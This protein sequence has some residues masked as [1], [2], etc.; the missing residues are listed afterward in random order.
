TQQL[1]PDLATSWKVENAGRTIVFQLREGIS[2][3]DGT[4][5]TAEDV[6]Y[7]MQVLMDPN[8]HSPTGDT[9]RS[10][11]GAVKTVVRGPCEVAITFPEPVA[12]LARFFDQV[13][14][15]SKNSPLKERAVLG[16]FRIAEH[17]PGTHILLARN[18][19]YW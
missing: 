1:A 18:P 7:T 13:A 3:S 19:N 15:L 14:I 2:F 16:P 8:L 4:P 5:F 11:T 12:G 17:K 10:G 6:A 9:F